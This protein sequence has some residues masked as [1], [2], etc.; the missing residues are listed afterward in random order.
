MKRICILLVI[1]GLAALGAK[2]LVI[3]PDKSP[4]EGVWYPKPQEPVKRLA[5]LPAVI[6]ITS[7]L[8]TN[9]PLNGR[10]QPVNGKA[11]SDFDVN[12]QRYVLYRARFSLAADDAANLSKLLINTFTR[13][14]VCAQVNGQIARRLYPNDAYAAAS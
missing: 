2:V 1:A 9:D 14:L 10:W 7:A 3:P 12:D 4:Q 11:L 5:T 6:R 13:D 8:K